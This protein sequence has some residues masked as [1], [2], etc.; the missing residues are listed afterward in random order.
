MKLSPATQARLSAGFTLQAAAKR[1]RVTPGT[2]RQ[3][4]RSTPPLIFAER[5]RDLYRCRLDVFL[6]TPGSDK[7]NGSH[8]AGVRGGADSAL[9]ESKGDAFASRATADQTE[10]RNG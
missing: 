8:G 7:L 5:A 4:E 10:E 1:L 6:Y 2:L 9:P 3:Y